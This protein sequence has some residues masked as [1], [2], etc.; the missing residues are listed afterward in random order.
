MNRIVFKNEKGEMISIVATGMSL[1]SRKV[2]QG[3]IFCACAASISQVN[4]LEQESANKKERIRLS[5]HGLSYVK[6]ALSRGAIACLWEPTAEL[7]IATDAQGIAGEDISIPFYKIKNLTLKLGELA[8]QFYQQPSQYMQVV[9]ITGTNGKTSI[10]YFIAQ[11]MT[12]VG[13]KC[14][15]IGTLGNGLYEQTQQSSHTTPDAINTQQLLAS[16]YAQQAEVIAMEVSSHA[17]HQSRVAGVDFDIAVFT[18][19]TRDH[20]DYHGSMENYAN[21]KKKLFQFKSLSTAVINLDD[22]LADSIIKLVNRKK[23]KLVA[24]SQEV[25]DSQKRYADKK[26]GADELVYATNIQLH[27]LGSDFDL[28]VGE[29]TCAVKLS[30]IGKFNISNALATASVLHVMGFD[31][32]VIGDLLGKLKSVPGRMELI[33]GENDPQIQIVIDYA[34]TPDALKQALTALQQH[35]NNNLWCIF[36]CG[37]NRDK[38]KRFDMAKI[39]SCY[40]DKVIVTSDNPRNEAPLDIIADIER[41]MDKNKKYWVE[42]DRKQAIKQAIGLAQKGD[43]LLLAG[44]GHE[45]YQEI[46]GVR[47]AYSDK[48]TCQELLAA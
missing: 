23:T 19:L 41:G 45:D 47:L 6:D 46:N 35:K 10:S 3:D 15:V 20:L 5:A 17:L 25:T 40:A 34:H 43:I 14:G 21:E 29:E 30:L 24:Y 26:M 12:S 22:D 27:V 2:K 48:K 11:A 13:K 42:V 1:D 28:C 33:K 16:M 36:G 4:E 39:A 38:G 37:G 8:S 7:K 9:G 31:L 18:N 32:N 44:K